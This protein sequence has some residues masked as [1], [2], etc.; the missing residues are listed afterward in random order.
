MIRYHMLTY[1]VLLLLKQ[2]SVSF[3]KESRRRSEQASKWTPV[4]RD[5]GQKNEGTTQ[6]LQS[7]VSLFTL[8]I[9]LKAK[10]A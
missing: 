4:D 7:Q 5:R 8:D 6:F 1:H 9:Q 3:N 10:S 2:C